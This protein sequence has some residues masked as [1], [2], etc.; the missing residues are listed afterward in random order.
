Q[1]TLAP[2]LFAQVSGFQQVLPPRLGGPLGLIEH[3]PN[4]DVVFCVH[5]GFEGAGTFNDLMRGTLVNAV[6]RVGFWRVPSAAIPRQ[7]DAQVRWLFE[8]WQ[9][10]DEWI[11]AKRRAPQSYPSAS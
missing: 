5:T 9:R 2:D 11:V 8:Q 7:H 3:C 4:V 6:I 10:V 1:S